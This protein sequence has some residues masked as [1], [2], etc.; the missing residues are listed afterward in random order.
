MRE[1]EPFSGRLWVKSHPLWKERIHGPHRGCDD[2]LV[3][4]DHPDRR[5]SLADAQWQRLCQRSTTSPTVRASSA[6]FAP[7]ADPSLIA[8]YDAADSA[9]ITGSTVSVWADKAGSADLDQD[10]SSRQPTSGARSHN[11]LNVVDFTNGTWMASSLSL[12]TSG[13]VAVHIALILDEADSEYAALLAF[14]ATNDMQL[15]AR[16]N[17]QFAGRLNVTGIGDSANFSGGP[18]SGAMILSAVFDQ[19]GAGTSEVFI[20]D[21]LRAS[22]AYTTPLD[23]AAALHVM[24]NRARNAQVTGAVC[25]IVVTGDVD[26]VNRAAHHAYLAS[27]WGMT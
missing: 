2:Q 1:C 9:T 3:D 20:G 19:S 26:A 8:W 25:E 6:G 4:S 27:K 7:W 18:F 15:D 5:R 14:E 22:A 11:G 10:N 16:S 17:S 12:P 24:I 21:V 23:A 13:D